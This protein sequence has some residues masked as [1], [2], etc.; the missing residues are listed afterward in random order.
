MFIFDIR[1]QPIR[2]NVTFTHMFQRSTQ[3]V[4]T[5]PIFFY[6]MNRYYD[7]KNPL[8]IRSVSRMSEL[9]LVAG[10]FVIWL[11]LFF[12]LPLFPGAAFKMLFK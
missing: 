7:V 3:S 9:K 11:V 1:K 6:Y 5:V 12:A 10:D 8:R 4:I 2:C